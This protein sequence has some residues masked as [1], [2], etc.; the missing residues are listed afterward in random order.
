MVDSVNTT[1]EELRRRGATIVTEP[2]DLPV[3]SRRLAFFSDP[4][5]NLFELAQVLS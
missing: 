1:V 5:G 4:W 2:F 3:I